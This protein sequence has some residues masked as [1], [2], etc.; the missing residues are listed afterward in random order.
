MD[1]AVDSSGNVHVVGSRRQ[2]A[3]LANDFPTLNAVQPSQ[4]GT[5]DAFVTKIGSANR[6]PTPDAGGDQ[7]VECSSPNGTAVTLD[8]TG[9]TDPDDDTLTYTWTGP[10]V[11]GGGTVT[12]SS[13][14]VTLPEGISLITIVV[15]DGQAPTVSDTVF[16]T[17][18]DKTPPMLVLPANLEVACSD[19]ATSDDPVIANWLASATAS[20]AC[21]ASPTITHDGPTLYPRGTTAVVFTAADAAEN[22]IQKTG[23]VQVIY[24]FAGFGRPLGGFTSI[25]QNKSGRT[26]PVKFQLLCIGTPVGEAVATISVFKLLEAASGRLDATDLAADSGQANDD[27]NR[28][29]FD[30]IGQQYIFN[31]STTGFE[32]PATYRIFV[33]LDDGTRKSIDFSLR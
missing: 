19:Q 25:K 5:T 12:G 31:L 32:A 4:I 2:F 24:T 21:D 17:V 13:P 23:T 16:V 15:D 9:S 20:D 27:G 18:R 30:P 22:S 3:G 1:V 28:F 10:F 26:I 29:R 8:G 6:A 33:D 11:E 14:V 7:T